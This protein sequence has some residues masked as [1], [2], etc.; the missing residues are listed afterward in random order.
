MSNKYNPVNKRNGT[1]GVK[2]HRRSKLW[3]YMIMNRFSDC[4]EASLYTFRTQALARA[5]GMTRKRYYDSL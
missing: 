1:Y 3:R 5:E 2:T 4:V